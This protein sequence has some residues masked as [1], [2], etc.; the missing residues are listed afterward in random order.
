[1]FRLLCSWQYCPYNL[2]AL[3][4]A[5]LPL[6]FVRYIRSSTTFISYTILMEV[7]LYY[8]SYA[9]F[10]AIW[11]LCQSC[12]SVLVGNFLFKQFCLALSISWWIAKVF[13]SNLKLKKFWSNIIPYKLS[14]KSKSNNTYWYLK[15]SLLNF[16]IILTT[17][18]P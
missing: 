12:E 15:S 14:R 11:T 8:I 18:L 3:F 10:M 9:I 4:L 7:L 1:M 2:Y 17:S 13:I 5:V 6:Y 16:R